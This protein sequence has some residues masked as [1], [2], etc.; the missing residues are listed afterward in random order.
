LNG[1]RRLNGWN[2]WNGPIPVANDVVSVSALLLN[3]RTRGG[4][5]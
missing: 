3:Y 5:L 2:N 4:L 1:A